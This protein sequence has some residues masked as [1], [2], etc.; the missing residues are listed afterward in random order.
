MQKKCLTIHQNTGNCLWNLLFSCCMCSPELKWRLWLQNVFFFFFL[1]VVHPSVHF[2]ICLRASHLTN[3]SRLTDC[4]VSHRRWLLWIDT[5][6]QTE[7][8]QLS[9]TLQE[10]VC[11]LLSSDWRPQCVVERRLR[12][13]MFCRMTH[14][15]SDDSTASLSSVCP[16]YLP[17]LPSV[18][19]SPL[20]SAAGWVDGSSSAPLHATRWEHGAPWRQILPPHHL[21]LLHLL[22]PQQWGTSW[23]FHQV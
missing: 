12:F 3:Y 21:L 16:S 14:R 4:V 15:G 7:A 22:L 13:C 6:V 18:L 5:R 23:I 10:T 11:V 20:L 8:H 2:S 9:E 1:I 19:S 17:P